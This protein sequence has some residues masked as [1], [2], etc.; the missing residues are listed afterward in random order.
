MTKR[1]LYLANSSRKKLKAEDDF[2]FPLLCHLRSKQLLQKFWC[3]SNPT[4][5]HFKSCEVPFCGEIHQQ[6]SIFHRWNSVKSSRLLQLSQ[7]NPSGSWDLAVRHTKS[8]SSPMA[9]G[10]AA[11]CAEIS[12]LLVKLGVQIDWEILKLFISINILWFW[13]WK[14]NLGVSTVNLWKLGNIFGAQYKLPKSLTRSKHWG[15]SLHLSS[16]VFDASLN[17]LSS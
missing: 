7:V 12:K 2:P 11:A 9:R 4:C 10:Q 14:N 3:G 5:C 15:G 16:G 6:S 1:Q 13:F 8:S 17:R